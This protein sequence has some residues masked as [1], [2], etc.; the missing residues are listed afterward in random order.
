MTNPTWHD[1]GICQT[2][3]P[4]IFY[5]E[6]GDSDTTARKICAGCPVRRTCLDHAL[7]KPEWHGVWGGISQNE[8][9]RLIR[10]RRAEAA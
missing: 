7:T 8:R 9:R 4:A 5:P 2:T 3:D 10:A 6:P 1:E